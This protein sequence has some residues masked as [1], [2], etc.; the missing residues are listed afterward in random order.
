MKYYKDENNQVY[1]FEADGSQ[2]SFIKVGLF[3][4]T[5]LEADELRIPK[6][7]SSKEEVNALITSKLLEIDGKKIRALTDAI[8]TGDKTLLQQLENAAKSERIKFIK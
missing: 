4:I 1:A 6:P 8:L 7:P 3:A 2:D 5:E